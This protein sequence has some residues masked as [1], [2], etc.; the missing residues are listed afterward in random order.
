VLLDSAKISRIAD[1]VAGLSARFDAMTSRK[2]ASITPSEYKRLV[3]AKND[4]QAELAALY[5]TAEKNGCAGLNFRN[6]EAN[7]TT[8]SNELAA[9]QVKMSKGWKG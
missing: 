1:G 5:K 3:K 4:A 9:A 2:D 6:L 8:A 7:Y